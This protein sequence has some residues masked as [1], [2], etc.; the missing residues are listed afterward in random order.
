MTEKKIRTTIL[1]RIEQLGEEEQ[2]LIMTKYL[3]GTDDLYEVIYY[4]TRIKL[5]IINIYYTVQVM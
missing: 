3:G 4:F 5:E 1:R 2:E